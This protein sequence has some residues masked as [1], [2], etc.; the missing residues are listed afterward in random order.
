[1][2]SSNVE[3]VR[4]KR[5]KMSDSRLLLDFEAIAMVEEQMG[6]AVS[7]D[8]NALFK[9]NLDSGCCD[10]I[11]I[12][13]DEDLE[14]KRLYTYAVYINDK[15][16][17]VPYSA[18]EIAVYNVKINQIYKL[19]L[20]EKDSVQY[21]SY[22]KNA[23]FS[24]AFLNN[25]Y[26]YMLP[27]TYPAIIKINVE[28]D[29]IVYYSDW[30]GTQEYLF[31]KSFVLSD[32]K[33]F[34]SSSI[35]NNILEFDLKADQGV[36]HH[37]GHKN[38]GSWGIVKYQDNI[39]LSPQKQG[40]IIKWNPI[41]GEYMEYTDFPFDF[42]GRD[43]MFTQ[44]FENNG[45]LYLIPAYANMGIEISKYGDMKEWNEIYLNENHVTRYMFELSAKIY[46]WISEKNEERRICINKINNSIEEYSFYCFPEKYH[47]DY[48]KECV[49]QK[50]PCKESRKFK[51][52]DLINM[53]SN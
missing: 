4:I 50:V 16:Y 30:V 3:S 24:C 51:L 18:N 47:H 17:F 37:I 20:E 45:N 48:Y 35:N 40:P 14:G 49:K 34:V 12:I 11:T 7:Y 36:W 52:T 44:I 33:I 22:K 8:F 27:A 41:T 19:E 10:Y 29:E 53:I 2:V 15:V 13:P 23:K 9:V 21:N 38:R 26:I 5:K 32:D 42:I 25:K 6:F 1:M 31:R 46:L 39:W 28:T 43:F